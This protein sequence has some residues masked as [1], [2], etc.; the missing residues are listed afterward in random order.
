MV[1]Y[2]NDVH[3]YK[4]LY[5]KIDNVPRGTFLQNVRVFHVKYIAMAMPR[6][7]A[8]SHSVYN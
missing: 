1:Q 6:Y 7:L 4:Y 3:T 8:L 2:A 5:K